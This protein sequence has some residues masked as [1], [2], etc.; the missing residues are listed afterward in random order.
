MKNTI[1]LFLFFF[2]NKNIYAQDK[3]IG[4]WTNENKTQTIQFYILNERYYARLVD[5]DSLYK[6][7]NTQ[8]LIINQMDKR[9]KT[10]LF[11]GTY[12]DDKTKN[13]YEIKIKLVNE[14]LFFLKRSRRLISK[15]KYWTRVNYKCF[16]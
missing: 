8:I 13:E 10:V 14:N 5:S 12:F 4:F 15:R 1:I 2:I 6:K 3:F 9:G 16:E 11:G 7:T